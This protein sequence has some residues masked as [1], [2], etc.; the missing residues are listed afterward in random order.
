MWNGVVVEY[1]SNSTTAM[2]NEFETGAMDAVF[3]IPANA[4][5]TVSMA[6]PPSYPT[7]PATFLKYD[8]VHSAPRCSHT[9]STLTDGLYTQK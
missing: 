1:Q 8:H 3:S 4:Q 2:L 6:L 9:Y 7:R 5:D